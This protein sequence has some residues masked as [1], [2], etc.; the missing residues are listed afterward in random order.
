M[1]CLPS[2][3]FGR[4]A[5]LVVLASLV[6][7]VGCGDDGDKNTNANNAPNNENPDAGQDE[8]DVDD[9]AGQDDMDAQEGDVPDVDDGRFPNQPG[10]NPLVPEI[11]ALPFPSD[12]Y[13]VDDPNT[14][15][16]RRME[17]PAEAFP[18]SAQPNAAE[19]N[20]AD[21]FSFIPLLVAYLPGGV[22]VATLPSP[23]DH[24][25]S[26]ADDSTV[27]LV[28]ADSGERVPLLAEINANHPEST[29]ASLLIRPLI[30]LK[31]NTRYVVILREGL[32]AIDGTPHVANDAF[33]ALRD[34]VPTEDPAVES[35][36]D[37]FVGINAAIADQ[38]LEPAG[39]V[40][41]WSFH[42]RSEEGAV[43]PL[44][45]A[46]QVANEAPVGEYTITEDFNDGTNRQVR[47][48]F[49]TPNFAS[50]DTGALEW[51]P[52]T[53]Q[54]TQFGLREVGFVMTIPN[55]VTE[56]RPVI[57]YGHGFLGTSIQATRGR[58]NRFCNENRFSVV[59]TEFGFFEDTLTPLSGALGGDGAQF[60]VLITEVLQSFA[61]TTHLTRIVKERMAA[62]LTVEGEGGP[63]SPFNTDEVHYLG[64]SNGGTFGYVHAA[65]SPQVE[66]AVLLVGGGGLVHF[67]ERA[68]P[69]NNFKIVARTFFSNPQEFQLFLAIVQLKLDRVDSMSFARRMVFNRYPGL[70]T[71]KAQIHM[72]INDS[73]VHNLVTEWV[74]RSV[75][76]PM[77]APS[78]KD[79]YGLETLNAA[80]EA[81]EDTLTA[82]YVYDED[83]EP[84]PIT[85]ETPDE[86]N[87]THGTVRDLLGYRSHAGTFLETGTFT[88]VCDGPCDPE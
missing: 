15:T 17:M 77:V 76:S 22:D 26:I 19:F 31:P 30:A 4:A 55:V 29:E 46:Q 51:D 80:P 83:V 67:L 59:G 23:V 48:T 75:P 3:A 37:D 50:P 61:N 79:V 54:I 88:M 53:G 82:F 58:F 56:P 18:S 74:A 5:L 72:A 35:Q 43:G 71:L 11:A 47:G 65:T 8:P 86:D 78:P 62:D 69:W 81:P 87:D 6:L 73:Q 68:E 10:G 45:A 49:M 40:L 12:F 25:E 70:P 27:F 1:L 84:S 66:R 60:D 16:G 64:I 32:K 20:G 63:V 38:G 44:L 7:A 13:L 85:N 33:A 34:G 57:M 28:E 9:D 52:Q 39:V 42:T 36:R 41:A 14:L 24:A 2:S 21:G